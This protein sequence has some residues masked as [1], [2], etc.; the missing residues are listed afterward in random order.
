MTGLCS[1]SRDELQRSNALMRELLAFG[2]S[3]SAEQDLT[4]LVEKIVFTA[5]ALCHADAGILYL[6][7]T[8]PDLSSLEQ[9]VGQLNCAVL[10]LDSLQ[11]NLNL[12]QSPSCATVAA[13]QLKSGEVSLVAQAA[14]LTWR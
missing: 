7:S 13:V 1:D 14:L 11:L 4:H 12:L 8:G 6:Q 5:K 10:Q 9:P 3:L 2:A